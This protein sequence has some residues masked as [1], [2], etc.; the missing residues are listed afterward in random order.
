MPKSFD[1]LFVT[2]DH[3]LSELYLLEDVGA[4]RVGTA[5]TLAGVYGDLYMMPYVEGF[6][7]LDNLIEWEKEEISVLQNNR[8][9]KAWNYLI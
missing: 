4:E 2:A 3:K 5:K 6:E 9:I 8:I 1:F 7:T